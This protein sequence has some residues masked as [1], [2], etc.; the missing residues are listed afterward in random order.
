MGSEITDLVVS[1]CTTTNDKK[2]E[3]LGGGKGGNVV[4]LCNNQDICQE[5]R[6]ESKLRGR[7]MTVSDIEKNI[8]QKC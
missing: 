4:R 3:R 1:S 2:N 6:K 8:D 7:H 5:R